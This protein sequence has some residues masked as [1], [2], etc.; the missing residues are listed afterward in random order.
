MGRKSRSE[1]AALLSRA[2][3]TNADGLLVL[4]LRGDGYQ[5]GYQHGVLARAQIRLFHAHVLDYFR[6]QASPARAV[7]ERATRSALRSMLTYQMARIRPLVPQE[8][9]AEMEG[10]AE[11]ASLTPYDILLLNVVWEHVAK[12]ECAHFAASQK[13]ASGPV[14][15]VN[16]AIPE[17]HALDWSRYRTLILA[18]P[19]E[20]YPFAHVGLVG[21]VGVIAGMGA[22]G[23]AVSWERRLGGA[24]PAWRRAGEPYRPVGLT[25]RRI[26]QFARNLHTAERIIRSDLPRPAEDTWLLSSAPENTSVGL[27][28]AVDQV[29]TQ[30][31]ADS[32]VASEG[33]FPEERP[34]EGRSARLWSLLT[35]FAGR[36][37]PVDVVRMLRDPY[38]PESQGLWHPL[39]AFVCHPDTL[40]S[41]A[42]SPGSGHIWTATGDP[43]APLGA[44]V[45]YTLSD[46]EPLQAIGHT[47]ST[48]FH[49]ARLACLHLLAG[50]WEQAHQQAT[51]A[52]ALDGPTVPLALIRARALAG[53]EKYPQAVQALQPALKPGVDRQYRAMAL[54]QL[55][56]LR[57]A[58]DKPNEA[59]KAA[60]SRD[61]LLSESQGQAMVA[62]PSTI[63]PIILLE[64]SNWMVSEGRAHP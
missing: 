59:A 10:I 60:A 13:G 37:E 9:W 15:A 1:G 56:Q 39:T 23:I 17:W 36:L 22:N 30:H 52:E 32:L 42:M 64:L 35:D 40:F 31:I 6:S 7:P 11:G 61:A 27:E 50:E 62:L 49:Q 24:L 19:A 57:I 48:G 18:Y 28:V 45:G 55:T 20:G 2:R 8:L 29:A 33:V 58:L 26:V 12:T 54:H 4:E 63:D 21:S 51:Q 5:M 38:P 44:W 34:Q 53:Q 47:S 43:P 3:F 16:L 46:G 14:H 41:V 25:G